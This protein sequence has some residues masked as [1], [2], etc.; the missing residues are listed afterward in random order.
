[1]TPVIRKRELGKATVPLVMKKLV[2]H[3]SKVLYLLRFGGSTTG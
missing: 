3:G 1:M 2:W